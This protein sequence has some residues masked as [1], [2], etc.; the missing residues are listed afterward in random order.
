[1]GIKGL[2]PQL[3]NIIERKHVSQYAGHKVAIDTYSWLH[4]GTY[5]CALELCTGAP[6]DKYITYCTDRVKMLL[7]NDVTPVMVFDG[8]DL[9][10]KDGTENS[11]K[12]LRE[13]NHA[14][15]MQALRTGNRGLATECFQRAVDVTPTMA[16]KLIK[17]LRKMDV[18][19]IVAP[20]E[21]DA[22]V[23]RPSSRLHDGVRVVLRACTS[24][25][26]RKASLFF[27]PY[28][29]SPA[30]E[31]ALS[32]PSCV[33]AASSRGPHPRPRSLPS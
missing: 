33:H 1:M 7:H 20:Y 32:S 31:S 16:H 3:R 19:V 13:V 29:C 6:T 30:A 25:C 10:S 4:K 11:R 27:V 21:A 5:C 24:E 14:K 2:L 26:A 12:N 28:T 9:P 18:E 22:Q 8:A 15:G 17:A 23:A